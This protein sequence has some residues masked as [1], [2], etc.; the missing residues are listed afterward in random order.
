MDVILL[1]LALKYHFEI[2]LTTY[3][4]QSPHLLLLTYN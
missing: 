4:K 2:I 3:A 1:K